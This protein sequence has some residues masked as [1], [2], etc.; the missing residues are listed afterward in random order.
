VPSLAHLY[1]CVGHSLIVW[2]SVGILT[3]FFAL[4][5]LVT[6]IG[7]LPFMTG[8]FNKVKPYLI[9]PSI[10]GTY[11]VRPLP[12]QIGYAPTTGQGLY[13]LAFVVVNIVMTATDYRLALPHAWYGSDKYYVGMA[14]VMWRTGAFALYYLPL[15]ILFSG[16]NNVLLWLSNWSHSTYMLLHRWVARVFAVHVI[17][18]SVLGLALYVKTGKLL[19]LSVPTRA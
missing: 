16:R 14:Y 6:I 4:P 5:I 13:I 19:E 12:Y 15:V 9:W 3:A 8:L 18:H 1:A 11:H 7:Y 17:L 2:T 10:M